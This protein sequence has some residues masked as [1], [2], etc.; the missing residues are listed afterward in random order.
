M[1]H[2][3]HQ[4]ASTDPDRTAADRS[5]PETDCPDTTDRTDSD[6]GHTDGSRRRFGPG[7]P[8]PRTFPAEGYEGRAYRARAEAMTV[9]PLR[10]GRY[11]VAREGR[12]Y[13]VDA[14]RATC[15]C[16]DSTI[17]GA[18][19]K[20]VRRVA[21]EIDAGFVP[22]P[23]ERER[24]CAVC[25]GPAFVTADAGGPALCSRHDH[26]PG[27][28][29]AD[30]ETGNLLVIAAATG[31]RADDARTDENR[32]V[33]D[34]DTNAAYGRHEPVFAARY[35]DAAGGRRAAAP[36]RTYLFP[37]SRLRPVDVDSATTDRSTG[38][39]RDPRVSPAGVG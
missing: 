4:S 31:R 25:G 36:G 17:R 8:G 12:T 26:A 14:E 23:D 30:R 6:A 19:C 3:A 18:R 27:D 35:V 33:A 39:T 34:Y 10:D 32:L 38:P 9:W 20:H 37:A 28:L 7:S 1:T 16:P 29:V 2:P 5:D 22:A 21:I 11:L 13:V 24:P 15:T